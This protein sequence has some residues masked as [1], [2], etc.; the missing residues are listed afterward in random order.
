MSKQTIYNRL[1]GSGLSRNGALSLMGNWECESNC[2]PCRVQ[3][4]FLSDRAKSRS[5]A[6]RVDN[7]LISE[8][9]WARDGLGWGLA[10]WT[11]HSRK[12]DLLQFCRRVSISIANEEAQVDFAVMELRTSYRSVW[13]ELTGDIDLLSGCGIVCKRYE[14]PAVNNINDRYQ[15]ALR[16]AAQIEDA[17]QA[18]AAQEP[19]GEPQEN[20]FWP[21]RVLCTGMNGADVEALQG[22]LYAHGYT[23][24]ST[25]GVFSDSTERAVRKFQSDRGLAVDGIAGPITWAAITRL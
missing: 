12:R 20:T 7:G 5:Y 16:I 18:P 4:D 24:G 3:G 23:Y 25:R 17:Q 22:L 21:P 10:Q 15:A 1:R 11:Y 13:D 6:D 9:E 2:E 14:Q 8:E 19:T